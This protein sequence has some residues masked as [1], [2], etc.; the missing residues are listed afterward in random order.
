MREGGACRV[1]GK[2][3]ERTLECKTAVK[4]KRVA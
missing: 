4:K 2:K 3:G 1:E